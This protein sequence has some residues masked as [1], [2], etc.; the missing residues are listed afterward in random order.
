MGRIYVADALR[1]QGIA[2][3]AEDGWMTRG[4]STGFAPRGVALH[5]TAV[6]S[7]DA[8][9]YPALEVCR[10]G[11]PDLNGPLCHLLVGRRGGIHMIATGRANHAGPIRASGP[12]PD[13]DGNSL[14]VGI[15][16]DYH[17]DYQEVGLEQRRSALIAAAVILHSLGQRSASYVRGHLEICDPPGRKIDPSNFRT[18]MDGARRSIQDAMNARGWGY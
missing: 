3:H 16:I 7:S 13:G 1:K 8:D 4:S 2:V 11:R 9:P 15:E 6:R 17:P 12:M 5:H 18:S 10:N 14:Y